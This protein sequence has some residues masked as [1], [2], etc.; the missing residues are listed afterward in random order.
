MYR[1]PRPSYAPAY[2]TVQ[3]D[4]LAIL[5]FRSETLDE[6][7]YISIVSTE[8]VYRWMSECCVHAK[9]AP[10]TGKDTV[11]TE[12]CV[13]L[14]EL[15]TLSRAS[16]QCYSNVLCRLLC[17]QTLYGPNVGCLLLDLGCLRKVND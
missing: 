6:T 12:R 11:R 3:I 1:L 8:L 15:S 10:L 13:N 4:F 16:I 7:E 17:Y 9:S 2:H 5:E 14:I